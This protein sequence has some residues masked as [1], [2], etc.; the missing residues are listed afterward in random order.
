MANKE[1]IL[2]LQH[3]VILGKFIIPYFQNY[4]EY[5]QLVVTIFDFLELE[6]TKLNSFLCYY[7]GVVY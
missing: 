4:P 1:V 7:M 6:A 2:V 3:V 5:F